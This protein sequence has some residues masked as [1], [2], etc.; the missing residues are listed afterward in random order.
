MGLF[1]LFKKQELPPVEEKASIGPAQMLISKDHSYPST[2]SEDYAKEGYEANP[3]V[4]ACVNL[5]ATAFSRVPLKAYDA[6]GE[7]VEDSDLQ[8]LL[9]YPNVDEG[10]VEFRQSAASWM[11]LTGNCYTERL[12]S[13]GVPS[14][15]WLW[16]PYDMSVGRAQGSRIPSR[17]VWRKGMTGEKQ[18]DVDLVSGKSD[19]MHWRTFNPNPSDSTFGL[20][21]M[22]AA[23]IAADT[24]NAAMKW[25]FNSVKNGGTMDGLLS[26]KGAAAMDQKQKQSLERTLN[27]RFKGTSRAGQK[28]GVSS[29]EMAYTSMTSSMRD[30]EWLNGT[31]LSKQEIAE[32][33]KVP[34]QLLGIEGSQTYANFSEANLAFFKQA[35]IPLLD[36]YCSEMNR[37]LGEF[38]P[39]LTIGYSKSDIDAL[40]Q[41]R[42]ERR[43][44]KIASGAY[45]INEIRAEFG[46]APREE[47]EADYVMTNPQQIPLG[48][49]IFT[50]AEAPASDVAKALM[51]SGMPKAQAEQKALD[52]LYDSENIKRG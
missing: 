30:A 36:L 45:S 17:Y 9:D 43:D 46:D 8:R 31:K 49:D 15:L 25:R 14:E 39:N 52:W 28:I 22:S 48:M 34:T 38:F 26:P 29:V 13:R 37:W 23:A 24:Y 18:W 11:L 51:R 3:T 47:M 12:L 27:E 35:V 5:I 40:E 10:G 7:A 4:F 16:Q 21:P 42:K 20:A 50:E 1:D 32:V 2:K 44:Q 41:D 6:D 19:M 33:F